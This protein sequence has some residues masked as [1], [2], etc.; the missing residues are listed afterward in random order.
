MYI[1]IVIIEF[2]Q[3]S[4]QYAQHIKQF[5]NVAKTLLKLSE[6]QQRLG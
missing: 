2:I 3:R 5:I 4:I 1:I 6:T